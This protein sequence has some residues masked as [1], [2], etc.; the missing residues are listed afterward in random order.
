MISFV[1][2][3]HELTDAFRARGLKVTPQRQLLF[4]LLHGNDQHP[5]ADTLFATASAEM[6]G[7]ALRTV[8]QTLTDLV[9]MGELR[10][11]TFGAGPARFDPNVD[12]HHHVLCEECGAVRDVY[13]AGAD[14]LEVLG[15]DGFEPES[16]AIVFR[17]R[18]PS[19]RTDDD[20]PG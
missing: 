12:E 9:A 2:A 16:T 6:P 8:Y 13:V 10:Q 4:R 18:C 19:C 3:P 20:H 7:I 11:V 17:G 5:T 14:H 15:L 1:R